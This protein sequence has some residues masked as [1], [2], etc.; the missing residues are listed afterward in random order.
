MNS[1]LLYKNMVNALI[2]N[3]NLEAPM[4]SGVE[5]KGQKK[6]IFWRAHYL[7]KIYKCACYHNNLY[8][9]NRILE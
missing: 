5:A 3:P 6:T 7:L 8:K 4:L 9:I 1:A 2:S